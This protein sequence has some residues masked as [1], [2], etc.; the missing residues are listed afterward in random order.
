MKTYLR[1]LSHASPYGKIIP[2]YIIL[3][4][5]YILF[6]MV[7]FSILVPLLE[8]LFDQVDIEETKKLSQ[9]NNFSFSVDYI[10]SL[11]YTY[12]N[13]LIT[14]GGRKEALQFVCIVILCSVFL[15]NLF[16]YFSAVILA[17]VRVRVVTNLRNS[18]FNKI[19]NF[20]INFFTE[21]KKGD[22]ISRVTSDIQQIENSVINSITVL[23]KEPALVIGLFFILSSISIKLTLYTIILIPIAGGAIAYIAKHLKIKAAFSQTALGNINNIINE[24]LDGMRIIKLFTAQDKMR[25]K[26]GDEVK[27]YGRQNLS[28]YKRFE[29]SN[30][31]SEFLSIATVAI[32]L[33]IGGGMVLDNSSEISASEFIAFIIIF[34]QVIPPAKT[35]TTAF[36]TVQRGLASAERVFEYIDKEKIRESVGGEKEIEDVK[37]SIEFKG[38]TFSYEEENVLE[39]ISFKIN[40]GEKIAIVG[41]SGGGK[42]T[43]IDLLSKFYRV[44]KGRILIDGTD[45]NEY[46]TNKLRNI[47]GIVTQESI[48]FHDTIR[49]NISFGD[50]NVNE[51]KIIESAN[52]ANALKFIESLDEK[53]DTVIGERG[54]KLS[55]GQRQRICIARAIYKDPPILVFDEATSSLDSE[56]ESSV[57]KAIEEVMK[58]RTSIIIAHRLSTIKNVDKI[59]VIDG[60]KIVEVGRHEELVKS[61]NVYSKFIKMQNI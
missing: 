25:D 35:M 32:I 31:L 7:N 5:F 15:A 9:N 47:I 51:K 57:Q 53:F 23:F 10:R 8:V 14:D 16:R 60:G 2:L 50:R 36:N 34:S 46:D 44:E 59:I 37:S 13:T 24:T 33:L 21:K 45:I 54:L 28:M 40:K 18:L 26:F 19:I 52:V 41:P 27:D 61:N 3:T 30:P 22:I 58:N 42:S 11:F 20:K 12:F 48:L 4:T 1:I 43:I 29:L 17:R 6:S 49:N 55:G 38:V 39:D 56:S